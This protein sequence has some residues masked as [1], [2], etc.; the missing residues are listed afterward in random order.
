[1]FLIILY[2]GTGCYLLLMRI[3]LLHREYMK[4]VDRHRR[5]G[6]TIL[7]IGLIVLGLYN[8]YY[9]YGQN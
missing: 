6:M 4:G 3:G 2:I 1:M 9:Y 8:I 7:A 5:S